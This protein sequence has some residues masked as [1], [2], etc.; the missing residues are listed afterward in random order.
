MARPGGTP[1]RAAS[2]APPAT[3]ATRRCAGHGLA[4]ARH[5]GRRRRRESRS[6]GRSISG[7]C[8]EAWCAC[9]FAPA[10]A[11]RRRARRSRV[12]RTESRCTTS[13]SRFPPPIARRVRWVTRRR[14]VAGEVRAMA[15]D[16]D[17]TPGSSRGEARLVW[18]G[19]RIGGIGRRC[20]R[21]ISAKCRSTL[22][23][24]G[25][26][27]LRPA[28]QRGRRSRASR[29]M[30]DSTRATASRSRLLLT[31]RRADQTELEAGALRDRD[32]GRRRLARRLARAVAMSRK[33]RRPRSTP[34]PRRHRGAG[35]D[36]AGAARST[37][38]TRC[39][40]AR[41]A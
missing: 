4:R 15:D 22:T 9:R 23:A 37:G 34:A 28:G 17:L 27:R 12:T 24:D 40:A 29:R 2:R 21:W 33:R 13:T 10:T 5:S 32:A 41:F 11:R 38:S 31:P 7:R 14:S 25:D 19:A 35:R 1:R 26:V 16:L 36:A 3:G 18:R 39:A 6:H 8:C 20:R 30:D